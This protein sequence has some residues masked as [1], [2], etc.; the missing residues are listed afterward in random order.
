[1]DKKVLVI[2][3]HP[4]DELLGCGGT[5]ARHAA[6]GNRVQSII[7]CEGESIRFKGKNV[8]Q[9]L[10]IEKARKVLGV[11]KV[12]TFQMPDQRLDTISLVD[13]ITP[14][15]KIVREFKPEIIFCQ[16]GDDI[17]RDHKIVSEAA[18]IAVRPVE[19]FIEE[20]YAF[21][22]V[23][24]TEWAYPMTFVADTWVNIE[25]YLEL[26]K[27]AFMCY[28]SEVREYPHPRSVQSL[29]NLAHYMGNECCLDSAEAFKTIRRIIR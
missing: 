16:Y 19:H 15:E 24:N 14:I 13:I 18:Q 8:N 11:E 25:N 17:N 12:H 21:Y 10:A 9:L 6:E 27:E 5:V 1:M 23:G 22:T 7:V 28:T 20:I 3:A 2:A 4:D 26:K 29:T